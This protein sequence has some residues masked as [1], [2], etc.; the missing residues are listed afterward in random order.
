MNFLDGPEGFNNE[1]QRQEGISAEREGS[2]IRELESLEG[3]PREERDAEAR[4]CRLAT[5]GNVSGELLNREITW[6][7]VKPEDSCNGQYPDNW[8]VIQ[9]ANRS[10]FQSMGP[11]P[12]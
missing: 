4:A 6:V 2:L 12:Y 11:V 10:S 9:P 5:R 8:T 7:S 1:M 3:K